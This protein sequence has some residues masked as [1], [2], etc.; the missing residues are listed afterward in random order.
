[1]GDSMKEALIAAAALVLVALPAA[2]DVTTQ[3][4]IALDAAG[5]VKMHGSTTEMTTSDK[6]RKDSEFHCEGFMS[7]FCGNARTGEIIRLDKDLAWQLRPDKKTYL[8]TPFPTPEERA[9]A[10]QKMQEE[11]DKIK[12]CQQ[13][14]QSKRPAQSRGDTSDCDLSPPKV[15]MRTTDEHVTIAGHDTRKSSVKMSQTCTDKKTG[16]VCELVYGFDVWLS[17]DQL[18]GVADKS[19][20]QR[21]YMTKMGLDLNGPQ[22]KGLTQQFMAQYAGTLKE[23]SAKAASLKGYPLRTTFRLIMGG[24]H[25]ASAQSD[26]NDNS[27]GGG[28][29]GLSGLAAN[30]GGKLLGGLFAKKNA[31]GA[32]DSTQGAIAANAAPPLPDGYAQVI[33]FTME[34]TAVTTAP[35]APEQFDLPAGWTLEQPKANKSRDFSC[36]TGKD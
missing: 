7:M 17:A 16:D 3:E 20:F 6:Q 31:A 25:C 15:D 9:V 4:S 34:T 29:G 36:P 28:G 26:A 10:Q 18:E 11:L 12:Q 14:Q 33:A 27:G 23:M 35:I 32:N 30:A 24:D 1:L 8:E 2:A 13:Q 5:V 19:A 22:L 21:A